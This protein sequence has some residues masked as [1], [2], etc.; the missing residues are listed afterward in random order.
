[1][2]VPAYGVSGPTDA[3]HPVLIPRR[4]LTGYDVGVA[5]EY[6]GVCHS[7]IH[8]CR[9]D[10][11]DSKYNP[12]LVPGHEIAGYVMGVGDQVTRFKEGDR[13]VIGNMTDSCQHCTSC[14]EGKEQYCLN[15]EPTWTYNSR[16]RVQPDGSRSLKPTGDVT[17]GGFSRYI[18]AQ[19]KFVLPLPKGIPMSLAAPLLC[20]GITMYSPLRQHQIGKGHV[21]GVAGI[22]GLG[23]LGLQFARSLGAQV[24]ALT[25]ST[26]KIP[27]CLQLGAHDVIFTPDAKQREKYKNK[28]DFIISTIPVSHEVKP[29]LDLLKPGK[30]KYHIVGDMNKFP[31]L[32]GMDFVF[33]G[34]ELTSSNVGG[35]PETKEM[36]QYCAQNKIFPIVQMIPISSINEAMVAI[37]AKQA[38]FRFVIPASSW[39]DS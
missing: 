28:F 32:K 13:V 6:A 20:A 2:K 7:D 34:R 24:I 25:T 9:N 31:D 22:G 26:W 21:V 16:E 19:E 35:I 4:N 30:G 33:K 36:L 39:T 18:V 5:I 8:H 14:Q 17:Y 27:F 23:H 1:M 38:R 15:I 29:Y 37:Q 11:G 3:L 10:W 12:I